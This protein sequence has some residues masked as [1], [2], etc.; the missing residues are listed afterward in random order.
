MSNILIPSYYSGFARNAAEAEY[1]ELW[2][3][4]VGAWLPFLGPTGLTLRDVSGHYNHGTL[5]NMDPATD[6]VTSRMGYVLDFDGANDYADCGNGTQLDITTKVTICAW[7]TANSILLQQI[8][9]RDDGTNRN[10][11]LDIVDVGG[12][13]YGATLVVFTS[14]SAYQSYTAGLTVGELYFAV[15]VY[16]GASITMYVNG[17]Q[18][19]TPLAHTGAIDN[20][21]VGFTI[22]ARENGADRFFGG[23]LYQTS[24]YARALLPQEIAFL[25]ANPYALVE[26]AEEQWGRKNLMPHFY[27]HY[28]QLAVA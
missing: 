15:G 17:A 11:Y 6:W 20:D 9:G 10:Y 24:I 27:H 1:P 7:F 19:G 25:Y 26:P 16:D 3:G 2:T 8:A 13:E 22:G 5:T 23:R 4:L 14:N 18:S 21:D 28:K 12:G